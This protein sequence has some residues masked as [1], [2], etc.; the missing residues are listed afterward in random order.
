MSKHQIF[1]FDDKIRIPEYNHDYG[2]VETQAISV[3]NSRY[4]YFVQEKTI[5]P[6]KKENVLTV[7][8]LWT[9]NNSEYKVYS[10]EEEELCEF[11][12]L[13]ENEAAVIV[14][15]EDDISVLCAHINH[16]GKQVMMLSRVPIIEERHQEEELDEYR[17]MRYERGLTI[18]ACWR[19]GIRILELEWRREAIEVFVSE[20]AYE[21]EPFFLYTDPWREGD[22]IYCFESEPLQNSEEDRSFNGNLFAIDIIKKEIF[23]CPPRF[24]FEPSLCK[25]SGVTTVLMLG[26]FH[27]PGHTWVITRNSTQIATLNLWRLENDG[28]YF[29]TEVENHE[30]EVTMDVCADGSAL[31]ILETEINGTPKMINIR[32]REVPTLFSLARYAALKRFPAL[33]CDAY[34]TKL[35]S[36]RLFK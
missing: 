10:W 25:P 13:S 4:V 8:D 24:Q 15:T 1:P 26:V 29:I 12:E 3:G 31:L 33:R 23:S 22:I 9:G 6:R 14:E 30:Y 27:R 5:I 32:F 17:C 35:F 18:L 20:I 34:L 36:G 21:G 11:Y 19:F 2:V 16:K 7:Y 28:W